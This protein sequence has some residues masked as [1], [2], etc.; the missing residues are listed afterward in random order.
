MLDLESVVRGGLACKSIFRDHP[1][2]TSANFSPFL[3][4]TPIVGKL[5]N[6]EVLN[7][8]QGCRQWR[9]KFLTDQLTLSQPGGGGQVMFRVKVRV[10]SG[11]M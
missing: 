6:A 4:P 11:L 2:K 8:W 1:F 3:T 5:R 9:L 7:G 10:I